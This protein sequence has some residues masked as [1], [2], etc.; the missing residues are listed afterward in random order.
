M[1]LAPIALLTTAAALISGP[2]V[3]S[4]SAASSHITIKT[5]TTFGGRQDSSGTVL[6]QIR[7]AR[8]R[9]VR[10]V[11]GSSSRLYAASAV[12]TQCDTQQLVLVNDEKRLY[13]V[14]PL[15]DG[16]RMHGIAVVRNAADTRPVAQTVT[17]DAVDTGERRTFGALVAR[18][19]ITTT[20]AEWQENSGVTRRV[21]DGWYIDLGSH[22]CGDGWGNVESA[23]LIGGPS[24]GRTQFK[25]KGTART[26]WPLIETD[27]TTDAHG[28]FVS[29]TTLVEFSE[30]PLDPALFDV[31]SG[32]RA[33]LP[34][35]H[36]GF[37]LEKPDTVVN[38]VRHAVESAASWVHYTWS[39]MTSPGP[40]VRFTAQ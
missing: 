8:Q 10:A 13:G 14:S 23:A 17:F 28:T 4:P 12:I 21:Q 30:A 29:S 31:P 39:R 20:T 33:A 34:L 25:W 3:S 2:G 7:G 5:R 9:V 6:L 18:R 19:V 37:D 38:R 35:S 16:S 32:Y 36:G 22:D 24:A 27:R 15:S 26:G 40:T 1:R 11:E